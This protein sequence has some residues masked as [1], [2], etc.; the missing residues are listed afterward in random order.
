MWLA[1]CKIQQKYTCF[2]NDRSGTR[3]IRLSFSSSRPCCTLPP[4]TPYIDNSWVSR[5]TSVGHVFWGDADT[6]I[7]A[8]RVPG[9]IRTYSGN[10]RLPTYMLWEVPGY[11][12]E[13]AQILRFGT[14]VA[15]RTYPT[16]ED[17]PLKCFD[18]PRGIRIDVCITAYACLSELRECLAPKAR[19][20]TNMPGG[21]LRDRSVLLQGCLY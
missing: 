9:S 5:V 18:G 10:T 1:R 6:Y 15:Q 16:P 3:H 7:Y 20:I 11:L 13:Y 14:R 17:T 21:I 12:P 2:S 8:L 4:F 19:A